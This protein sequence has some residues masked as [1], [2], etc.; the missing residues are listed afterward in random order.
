MHPKLTSCNP[1][2]FITSV[3]VRPLCLE[4]TFRQQQKFLLYIKHKPYLRFG[5]GAPHRGWGL[6]QP[7]WGLWVSLHQRPGD[8][9]MK[10]SF[11]RGNSIVN[12]VK[13]GRLGTPYFMT[14]PGS[15]IKK[16]CCNTNSFTNL[17]RQ[18]TVQNVMSP[19]NS[20]TSEAAITPPS[21]PCREVTASTRTV[22]LWE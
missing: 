16:I 1:T 14:L 18:S 9:T 5:P 7:K 10:A 3:Q 4:G 22:L 17:L 21:E 8:V 15:R 12:T 2:N 20:C 19:S 13:K 11:T 6:E